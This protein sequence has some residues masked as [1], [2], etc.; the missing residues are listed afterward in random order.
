MNEQGSYAEAPD[1]QLL[2]YDISANVAIITLDRSET[3]NALNA[4]LLLE[5]SLAFELAEADLN[6]RC[7]IITGTGRAFAAGADIGNLQNLSDVF[8]GRE[9]ALAGQ[10]VMNTL[11]ALPFPTIAAINGFAFGGGLELAL[12][13]D[14]RVASREAKL[15]LPEVGLGLLPGYGGT[16]R[17]PRLIGQGRALDLILTGRHVSAEEALQLGLV[18]RVAD[19]AL[20]EAKD[21]A[22]QM[23]KNAPIALGLAKEAVVRGLDVTINQGLEIEADLFGLVATTSD[24]KEGTRAFLEKR[25]AVFKGQ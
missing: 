7:L 15:G 23:S 3:L 18:N 20:S 12:A 13:A 2:R 21:L 10:D 19:N 14:L 6:V 4:E 24:M 1:F 22:A 25:A 9:A 5:L 8:S 16:Q 11:S 17:L